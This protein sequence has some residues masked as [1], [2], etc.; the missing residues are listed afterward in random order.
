[1]EQCVTWLSVCHFDRG[2]SRGD[3]YTFGHG[4]IWYL[5]LANSITSICISATGSIVCLFVCR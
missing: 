1:M 5:R 2:E 3:I 4:I